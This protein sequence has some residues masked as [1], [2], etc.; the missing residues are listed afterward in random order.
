MLNFIIYNAQIYH[1]LS[2][3]FG[4]NLEIHLTQMPKY[5]LNQCI[6][7]ADTFWKFLKLII[8]Q[9]LKYALN[10]SIMAGE[11]FEIYLC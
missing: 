5:A 11:N 3:M 8:S 9:I 7:V 1:N 2:P 4:E 6:I 10:L